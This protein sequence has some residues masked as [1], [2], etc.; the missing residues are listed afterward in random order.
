MFPLYLASLIIILK[1]HDKGLYSLHV[2]TQ[3]K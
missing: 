3:V 2:M 1:M